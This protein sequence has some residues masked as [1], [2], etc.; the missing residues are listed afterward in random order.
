MTRH[1]E[2]ATEEKGFSAGLKGEGRAPPPVRGGG[3]AAP[4]GAVLDG[5]GGLQQRHVATPGHT[6][7]PGS[8][9]PA[10]SHS[11]L[12]TSCMCLAPAELMRS[13]KERKLLGCRHGEG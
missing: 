10:F 7:K 6:S 8:T 1:P 11:S 2:E 3:R 4:K 5:L 9:G 12:S 13:A